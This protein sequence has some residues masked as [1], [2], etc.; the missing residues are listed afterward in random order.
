MAEEAAVEN[1]ISRFFC[2]KCN[3]EIGRV[4]PVSWFKNKEN[5]YTIL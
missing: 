5:V 1:L 3:L 4:Q 2:H